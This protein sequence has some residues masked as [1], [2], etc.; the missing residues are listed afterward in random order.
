MRFVRRA[1]L[2]AVAPVVGL[3]VAAC[4]SSSQPDRPGASLPTVEVIPV[5]SISGAQRAD[6]DGVGIDVPSGF[7]TERF[8]RQEGATTILR[9]TA[10][11]A[12]DISVLVL[13][14]TRTDPLVT[15]SDVAASLYI[16]RQQTLGERDV[17]DVVDTQVAWP[18]F[19]AAV[20]FDAVESAEG[21][22]YDLR[23]VMTRDDPGTRLV[24]IQVWSLPGELEESAGWQMARTVRVDSW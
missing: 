19:P 22:S 10:K 23:A 16:Q 9:I 5:D 11:S 12:P 24:G 15:D 3:A 18:G 7:D 20:G 17:T 4:G 14:V 6:V 8:V 13:T 21:K 1:V 2:L